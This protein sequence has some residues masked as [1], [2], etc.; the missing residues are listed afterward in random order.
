[1][2]ILDESWWFLSLLPPRAAY[3]N[4]SWDSIQERKGLE[5]MDWELIYHSV[6]TVSSRPESVP[7][8]F[9]GSELQNQCCFL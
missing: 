1:M 3:E 2:D 8:V 9:D 6:C 5:A 4:T 7:M